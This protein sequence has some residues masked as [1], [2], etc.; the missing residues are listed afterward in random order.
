MNPTAPDPRLRDWLD[1]ANRAQAEARARG[2]PPTPAA[3]RAG[4]AAITR[5]CGGNGPELPWVRD[6]EIDTVPVRLYDPEPARP[7]AVCVYLHGGGHMA[8]SVDVYDPIC[9][10]L[11]AGAGCLV[12]SVE[13]RLAPEHPYPKGLDDCARVL[14][15]LRDWLAARGHALPGGLAVAGDSGGGALTATLC[16][17]A[18]HQPELKIARQVLIYPSLD[19]TL[20]Q[21]SVAQNGGGYL[22]EAS[23]IRWYFDNYFQYG[24]NRA[25]ASPLCMPT[26]GL[27]PTLL[28]TAGFC[29]LR[30]EGYAYAAR[31][32]EAGVPCTHLHLPGMVHAFLNLHELVPDACDAVYGAI[33]RFLASGLRLADAVQAPTA[34]GVNAWRPAPPDTP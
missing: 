11:A 9:R 32:R 3:A 7:K 2:E 34:Q 23:R 16:A 8:G 5:A 14:A 22:L 17:L 27:P 6:I 26:D 31:L 30:D 20:A 18:A 19:Y 4:L 28:V 29:P 21:P 33:G 10:R 24:E 15:R 1:N 25:A 12:V 13:Y